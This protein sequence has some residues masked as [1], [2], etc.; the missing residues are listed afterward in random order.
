[1]LTPIAR[2]LYE[3]YLLRI[4]GMEN[5]DKP[6]LN[7]HLIRITDRLLSLRRNGQTT[8]T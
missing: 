5:I 1:V 8:P 6:T 3:P 7:E 2:D 4:T